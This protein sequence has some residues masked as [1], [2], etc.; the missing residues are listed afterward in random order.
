MIRMR[1]LYPLLASLAISPSLLAGPLASIEGQVMQPGEYAL[2]NESRLFDVVG[3]AGVKADAYLLG[4]AWLHQPARDE[5]RKLKAGILFDLSALALDARL[6]DRP[7]LAV[8]ASRIRAEV[9]ALPV[10]GR[11]TNDLDPV[12]LELQRGANHRLADGDRLL[13]PVRPTTLRIVG[14]VAGNCEVGFRALR[15]ATD[16]LKDCPLHEF[17]ESD[18]LYVIQPDGK[19]RRLGIGLWNRE[20]PYTPAPGATLLVPVSERALH[21]V[22]EELNDDMAAFLATQALPMDGNSQ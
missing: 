15:P 3:P 16:Y 9:T 5:Q 11:R 7:E 20:P 10:T 13:Y 2:S 21:G 14:A 22:A 17:A 6:F 4:A 1:S 8:L 12:V 18:W 19:V